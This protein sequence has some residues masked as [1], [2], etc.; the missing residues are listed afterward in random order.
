MITLVTDQVPSFLNGNDPVSGRLLA[1][2][3]A[4][5]NTD[6]ARFY[7]T[8]HNGGIAIMDSQSVV[9]APA[10]DT[11]EIRAFFTMQPT[12]DT[13]YSTIP[14][15]IDGEITVFTAMQ[16]DFTADKK[17]LSAVPLTSLY[18]FLNTYFGQMPPF[19]PWYLDVSYRTRHGLCRH[20]AVQIGES[21]ASSAM[22]VAEW[23]NGALIGGV[24]TA[25]E[26]RRKGLAGQCVT[27][28]VG[29]LQSMQ[30][31]VWIC[32]YNETA[33]RLYRELGFVD[34]GT[35]TVIERKV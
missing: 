20:T 3:E 26:H 17:M 14:N 18:D 28:L 4:Y 9:C 11:E 12:V 32:P 16:A 7:K 31:T 5:R 27:A 6:I 19:E 29:S 21:I 13:V 24:A 25:T 15:V 22:T 35:V 33:H 23:S 2:W 8:E 30:K 1:W 34:S 10:E